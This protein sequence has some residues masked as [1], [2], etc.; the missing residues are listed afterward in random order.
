[1]SRERRADVGATVH[2]LIRSAH[3]MSDDDLWQAFP[4]SFGGAVSD[5]SLKATNL[6]LALGAA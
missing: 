2:A 3:R 6:K 5:P 1:M 4:G